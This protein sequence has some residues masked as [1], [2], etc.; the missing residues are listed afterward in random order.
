MRFP[1]CS[2]TS[3]SACTRS[4]VLL[5]MFT[6]VVPELARAGDASP[7]SA[8]STQSRG[9][10][11]AVK[12]ASRSV[13]TPAVAR[14]TAKPGRVEI[15]TPRLA[16]AKPAPGDS[17]PRGKQTITPEDLLKLPVEDFGSTTIAPYPIPGD[18]SPDAVTRPR[19]LNTPKAG[20]TMVAPMPPPLPP[21]TGPQRGR[22]QFRG[23]RPGDIKFQFDGRE[24]AELDS[25][26]GAIQLPR[27]LSGPAVIYP[28]A[29]RRDGVHGTVMVR[30]EVLAD[31]TTGKLEVESGEP[32]L[33]HAALEMLEHSKFEAGRIDGRPVT[34]W[35]MVPVKF[36]LH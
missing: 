13:R 14:R 15:G 9:A 18:D 35:T 36:T 11:S 31:G 21:S 30:V 34:V 26:E 16:P 29:A 33:R 3:V 24:Q 28:D 10:G 27:F 2:E 25:G 5:L 6:A 8:D 17:L 20:T 1:F 4:A 23:G 12:R 7:P 19:Q 22:L 32:R